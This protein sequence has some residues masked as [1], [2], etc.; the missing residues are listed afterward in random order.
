MGSLGQKLTLVDGGFRAF[1][2]SALAQPT[3]AETDHHGK[4][5]AALLSAEEPETSRL[6]NASRLGSDNL[7]CGAVTTARKTVVAGF[8]Q[9][10]TSAELRMTSRAR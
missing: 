7:N 10:S 4:S 3:R 5:A 2:A 8:G 1:V 6:A 9:F